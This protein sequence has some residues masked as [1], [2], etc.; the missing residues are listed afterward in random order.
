[1]NYNPH[2]KKFYLYVED[3]RNIL[4]EC[5]QKR[6]SFSIPLPNCEEHLTQKE[7]EVMQ[8]VSRITYIKF[9]IDT[10]EYR[11]LAIQLMREGKE[12]ELPTAGMEITSRPRIVLD[13]YGM[14]LSPNEE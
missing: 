7:I 8:S 11:K 5:R 14:R 2:R 9:H 3:N 13:F 12:V 10:S 1:M 6:V 4:L